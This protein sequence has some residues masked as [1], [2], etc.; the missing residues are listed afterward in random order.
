MTGCVPL[1]V[2]DIAQAIEQV[3]PLRWQES[4]DNAGLQVGDPEATVT[5]V[6]LCTDVTR[7]V[8]DEADRKSVV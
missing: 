7:A 3:A 2:E 8:I 1:R 4:Y 6:L 5:G